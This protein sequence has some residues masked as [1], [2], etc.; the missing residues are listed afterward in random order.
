MGMETRAGKTRWGDL[1]PAAA[2]KWGS[3]LRNKLVK[4]FA[5]LPMRGIFSRTGLASLFFR[6]AGQADFLAAIRGA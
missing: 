4:R 2:T 6:L 3:L 5:W 1:S